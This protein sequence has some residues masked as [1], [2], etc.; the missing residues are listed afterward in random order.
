MRDTLE[1]FKEK[2][3]KPEGKENIYL[4]IPEGGKE[5]RTYIRNAYE[6]FLKDTSNTRSNKLRKYLT[7]SGITDEEFIYS[8]MECYKKTSKILHGCSRSF[9][10]LYSIEKLTATF[11]DVP[12]LE[13]LEKICVEFVSKVNP[14]L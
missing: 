5:D 13:N 10:K 6:S 14:V 4:Q 7:N 12:E 9:R 3:L 1:T 2:V 8:C 11:A